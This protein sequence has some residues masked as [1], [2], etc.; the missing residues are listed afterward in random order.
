M[1]ICNRQLTSIIA[2]YLSWNL[3]VQSTIEKRKKHLTFRLFK[4][5]ASRELRPVVALF[6][7]RVF[8]S[9]FRWALPRWDWQPKARGQRLES[10]RNFDESVDAGKQ[11]TCVWEVGIHS[12]GLD[13]ICGRFWRCLASKWLLFLDVCEIL[14]LPPVPLFSSLRKRCLINLKQGMRFAYLFACTPYDLD[15]SCPSNVYPYCLQ[16]VP[17]LF[18]MNP[19][20]V[21]PYCL[22]CIP[23]LNEPVKCIT[24]LS[25]MYTRTVFNEDVK[26]SCPSNVYPYCL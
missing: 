17:E 7:I 1:C 8:F 23:V 24:V 4:S 9:I 2:F 16:C 15:R 13:P 11:H 12:F 19:S 21:Y 3:R 22:Q 18:S 25:S 14:Y 10:H 5:P 26:R 6:N 20:Y